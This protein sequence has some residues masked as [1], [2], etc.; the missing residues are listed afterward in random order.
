MA[1]QEKARAAYLQG[2]EDHSR[3]TLARPLTQDEF[4]RVLARYR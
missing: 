4:E 2:A 3:A 1:L